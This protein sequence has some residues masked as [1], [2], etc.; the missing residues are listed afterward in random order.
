MEKLN[1]IKPKKERVKRP[2]NAFLVWSCQKRAILAKNNPGKCCTIC[3][4]LLNS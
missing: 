4:K 1:E 3:F 2:M